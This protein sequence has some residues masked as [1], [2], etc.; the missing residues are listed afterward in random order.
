MPNRR[1]E[2]DVALRQMVTRRRIELL[3]L[4]WKGGVLT[5]WP[6]GLVAEV[7]LEPTTCRVWTECS[8]QL[9][10]SAIHQTLHYYSRCFFVCQHLFDDFFLFSFFGA[11]VGREPRFLPSVLLLSY[12][13][14]PL[15][16]ENFS[17]SLPETFKKRLTISLKC[18]IMGD[19][20]SRVGDKF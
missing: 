20:N 12:N 6:T 19:V 18:Y 3:L 9:S 16:T 15:S 14:S 11:I 1:L 17:R 13:L 2:S 5:S 7:G 10:Y 4:P 8:S